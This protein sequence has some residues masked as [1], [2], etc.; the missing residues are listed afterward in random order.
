[1]KLLVLTFIVLNGEGGGGKR[2]DCCFE[3]RILYNMI[4]LFMVKLYSRSWL[5]CLS[6]DGWLGF[7]QFMKLF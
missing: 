6:F 3:E 5:G 7:L 4:W 2:L 1:M